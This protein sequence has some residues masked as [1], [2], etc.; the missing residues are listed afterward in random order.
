M[1]VCATI[2]ESTVNDEMTFAFVTVVCVVQVTA[3]VTI[4][5][6]TLGAAFC[7]S[8][9]YITSGKVSAQH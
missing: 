8:R 6:V 1:I 9:G 5:V 3:L 2:K 4:V 7:C